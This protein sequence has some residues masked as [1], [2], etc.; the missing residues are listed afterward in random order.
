MSKRYA[1]QLSEHSYPVSALSWSP[2]SDSVVFP[3]GR[4]EL[5]IY[6]LSTDTTHS[7]ELR[8]GGLSRISCLEWSPDGTRIAAGGHGNHVEVLRP[9]GESLYTAE[10]QNTVTDMDWSPDAHY[11]ATSSIDRTIRVWDGQTGSL[12][13]SLSGH[14]N[15]VWSVSWTPDGR[16]LISTDQDGEVK[17]W[18]IATGQDFRTIVPVSGHA[19][20]AIW[21]RDMSSILVSTYDSTQ[22]QGRLLLMDPHGGRIWEMAVRY[23]SHHIAW[24][25]DGNQIAYGQPSTTGGQITI[26]TATGYPLCNL[27]GHGGGEVFEWAPNGAY[28]ATGGSNGLLRLYDAGAISLIPEMV[29]LSLTLLVP[30]FVTWARCCNLPASRAPGWSASCLLDLPINGHGRRCLEPSLH[31]SKERPRP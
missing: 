8:A 23:S 27:T 15:T 26:A 20:D 1:L 28:I 11:L 4:K 17:F 9:N 19:Y 3:V 14:G 7:M 6:D 18:D 31:P 30:C 16:G 21:S 29:P 2:G 22:G 5:C 12:M 13:V 10:H 25:P 24:S